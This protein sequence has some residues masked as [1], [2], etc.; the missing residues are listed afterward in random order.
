M[1]VRPPLRVGLIGNGALAGRIV[2]HLAAAHVPVEIAGVLVRSLDRV[3]GELPFVDSIDALLARR[4]DVV[5]ECAGQAAVRETAERVLAQG[6]DL[7]PASVGALVDESLLTAVMRAAAA[8][9]ATVRLPSGAIPGIDGLVA[10]RHVGI[11]SVLY[12]GT[13]PPEGLEGV[14]PVPGPDKVLVF[15]GTAREAVSRFPKNVN[16]TGTI[17]L[18]GIGFE[19][20]RVEVWVDPLA[21]TNLHELHAEGAFGTFSVSIRGVRIAPGSPST[22]LVAGSLVQA[23]L[24]SNYTSLALIA[25]PG[26]P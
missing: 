2:E 1:T 7:V 4:P 17:A 12:R 24:G 3:Q 8:S 21:K 19:R 23:A 16:L 26:G 15:R 5:I 6:V 14:E 10:A 22:R 25:N 9:G 20:T 11:A 18:A 13:V